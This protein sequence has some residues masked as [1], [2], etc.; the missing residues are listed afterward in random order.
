MK[1]KLLVV[2]GAATLLSVSCA[3]QKSATYTGEIMDSRCAQLSSHNQER[4]SNHTKSAEECSVVCVKGGATFVLVDEATKAVYQLDD[5]KKPKYFAG[6]KVN[7]TGTL[8]KATATIRVKGIDKA[9][10]SASSGW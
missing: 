4:E 7:V 9:P 8:D 6:L 10:G 5:Q 2:I 3:A 1:R